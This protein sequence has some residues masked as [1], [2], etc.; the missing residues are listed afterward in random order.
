M[1]KI[2]NLRKQKKMTQATLAA[3][4][5]VGQSAVAAWEAGI[6]KPRVDKLIIIAKVLDCSIDD[7]ITESD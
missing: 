5:G 1:C 4:C 7:L 3:V 2:R 6:N